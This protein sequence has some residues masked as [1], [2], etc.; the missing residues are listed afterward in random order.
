MTID[1]AQ[2]KAPRPRNASLGTDEGVRAFDFLHGRWDVRH[3]KLR[4]SL[5]TAISS[6]IL[7]APTRPIRYGCS[8]RPRACGRSI[9]STGVFRAPV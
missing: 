1:R 8:V 4:D 7:S 3:V 9:G 2:L 6:K 5:A